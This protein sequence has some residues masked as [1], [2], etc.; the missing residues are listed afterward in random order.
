MV[1]AEDVGQDEAE[2]VGPLAKIDVCHG[3]AV[4]PNHLAY[5]KRHGLV[6]VDKIARELELDDIAFF[7]RPHFL[8]SELSLL[9]S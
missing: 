2:Q 6:F 9:K 8:G 4:A 1:F 3:R 5:G 7:E